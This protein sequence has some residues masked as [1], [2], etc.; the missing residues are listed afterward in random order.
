[1]IIDNNNTA[2]TQSVKCINHI[3]NNIVNQIYISNEI[4]QIYHKQWGIIRVAVG[5]YLIC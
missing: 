4:N 3:V 5:R 1:M 2:I